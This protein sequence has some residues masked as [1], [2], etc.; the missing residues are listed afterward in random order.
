MTAPATGF[1]IPRLTLP[2][3]WGLA[4]KTRRQR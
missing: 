1:P 3:T 2:T 4:K